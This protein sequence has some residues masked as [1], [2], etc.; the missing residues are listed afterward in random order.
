MD[1]RKHED[2]ELFYGSETLY[3]EV[4]EGMKTVSNKGS[5]DHR[6]I[7]SY[8]FMVMFIMNQA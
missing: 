4:I 5:I 3:K 1:Y 8:L 7:S 2:I 6:G